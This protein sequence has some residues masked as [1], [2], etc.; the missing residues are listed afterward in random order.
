[1]S[2][3][4]RIRQRRPED[5]PQVIGIFHAIYPGSPSW[6]PEQLTSHLD[7]FPEGQLVAE[8]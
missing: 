8:A 2:A 6:T 7:V 5:T 4:V 3:T 1:M